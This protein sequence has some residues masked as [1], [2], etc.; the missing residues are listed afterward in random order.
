MRNKFLRFLVPV[1]WTVSVLW[2]MSVGAVLASVQRQG[3][4]TNP[5]EIL[6]WILTGGAAYLAG[7]FVSWAGEKWTWF[8]SLTPEWKL[9]FQVLTSIS[10]AAVAYLAL[11]NVPPS[12]WSA[13]VP[14]L[15]IIVPLILAAYENQ[16][17]HRSQKAK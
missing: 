15:K 4:Y 10:L 11:Q 12:F 16:R 17:Y 8:Q 9:Y 7:R 14:Y 2:F 3:D 13:V 6:N 1:I 5:V